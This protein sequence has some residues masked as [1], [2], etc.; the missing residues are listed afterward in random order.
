MKLDI[1]NINNDVTGQVDLQQ[2]I[3][4]LEPQADILYKVIHWQLA[5]RRAGTHQV[6]ERGDVSG[7][8][9][10]IYKQKGTGRARHGAIRGAQFRGGGIIFGPHFRDHGYKLNKKVRKL[11]LKFALSS[12]LKDVQLSILDSLN[13]ATPKTAELKSSL[14]KFNAKSILIIDNKVNDNARNSCANLHT[15]NVLPVEGMNVYDIVRHEKV[16]ITV[17]ALNA[18]KERLA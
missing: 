5:K 15:V 11:G 3:F 12:K 8:T 16:L 2:E 1:V 14:S 4:G 18:I 10:K 17:D 13:L 7:S 6:K 9:R